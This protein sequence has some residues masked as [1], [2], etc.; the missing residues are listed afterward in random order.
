M[1]LMELSLSKEKLS[2]DVIETKIS[3]IVLIQLTWTLCRIEDV[4]ETFD[5]QSGK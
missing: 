4:F 3:R 2:G 1:I 5:Q